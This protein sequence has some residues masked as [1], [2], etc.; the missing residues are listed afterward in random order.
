MQEILIIAYFSISIV[1]EVID[2]VFFFTPTHEDDKLIEK[3]KGFWN[4]YKKYIFVLN[5][6]LPITLMFYMAHILIT[7]LIIFIKYGYTKY[8]NR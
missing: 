1:I 3:I 6:R 7:T 4:E 8:K 5:I 2:L